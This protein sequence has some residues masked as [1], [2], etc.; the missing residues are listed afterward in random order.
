MNPL[1]KRIRTS[2][3]LRYDLPS[4]V[5]TPEPRSDL[6]IGTLDSS[7]VELLKCVNPDID[8]AVEDAKFRAGMKCYVA[9]LDDMLV[10]YAWVQDSGLHVLKG[11]GR[12]RR[13]LEGE[14]WILACFTAV[15][16]RGRRIYPTVLQRILHDYK[17]NGFRTAWIYTEVKNTASQSGIRHAGF[18]LD[19]RLR[20]LAFRSDAIPLP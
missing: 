3:L 11:T 1:A 12:S 5:A 15:W 2:L 9:R 16:A 19:S 10:H 18:A 13:V 20:A 6:D 7:Q 17:A 4:L 8:C 14:L